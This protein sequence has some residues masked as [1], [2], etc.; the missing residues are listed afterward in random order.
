[1]RAIINLFTMK[2]INHMLK[3]LHAVK[4]MGTIIGLFF[5]SCLFAQQVNSRKL[6][7][8]DEAPEF[9]TFKWIKGDSVGNLKEGQIYIIEFSGVGCAPCRASIPHL[10][11]VATTYR[12]KVT[13]ISI[14][15]LENGAFPARDTV[16]TGYI[17]RVD[18]FI[19]RMGNEIQY[20]VAVDTPDQFM[21]RHWLNASANNGI[22][23]VFIVNNDRRIAWMGHPLKMDNMLQE[24]LK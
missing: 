4:W 9:R 22:P 19:N 16:S 24:I 21:Y 5:T 7:V 18:K 13:L 10:T 20:N 2:N 11:S 6:R 3:S 14:Y 1:M 17:E 15:V 12:N 8:G 23:Q